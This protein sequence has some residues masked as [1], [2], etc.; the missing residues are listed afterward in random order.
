M[1]K[2]KRPSLK[3]NDRVTLRF[4]AIPAYGGKPFV[5][6]DTVLR[7]SSVS[8]KGTVRDPWMVSVTDDAGSF[9]SLPPDDFVAAR[10]GTHHM[11]KGATDM[12]ISEKRWELEKSETY[13]ALQDARQYNTDTDRTG[14]KAEAIYDRLARANSVMRPWSNDGNAEQ[15]K[16][17]NEYLTEITSILSHKIGPASR[18]EFVEQGG[19]R[20]HLSKRRSHLTKGTGAG[21]GKFKASSAATKA[22]EKLV[23][24]TT[25]RYFQSIPLDTIFGIVEAQGFKF[26]PEEKECILAGRTGRSTWDLFG[27]DGRK[28]NHMLVVQWHK[29]DTTGRYELVSYVS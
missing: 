10:G 21:S 27:P 19:K 20:S 6:K 22:S 3:I 29:M 14:A 13:R 16:K 4:R 11:R 2:T 17:A 9:W 12:S 24:L 23:D 5:G 7:V 28:V 15:K 1:A 26:D 18:R 8:G 25:N